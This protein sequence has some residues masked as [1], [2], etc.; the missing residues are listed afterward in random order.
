MSI[1]LSTFPG[2]IKLD[3]SDNRAQLPIIQ[4]PTPEKLVYPLTG[5]NSALLPVIRSADKVQ[6][7]D[8][9]AQADTFE[10]GIIRAGAT[11]IA[12]VKDDAI[13]LSHCEAQAHSPIIEITGNAVE[14]LYKLGVQGLGGAAFSTSGKLLSGADHDIHT[15]IINAAECEPV[16]CCDQA[17][18]RERADAIIHGI[19]CL[20]SISGA[21][22]CIIAI[23]DTMPIELALLNKALEQALAQSDH[24][25]QT[26]HLHKISIATIPTIYPTGSEKQLIRVLTGI[27]L[28]PEQ[29]P[30]DQGILCFNIA[31]AFA[32]QQALIDSHPQLDRVVTVATSE[33]TP[34]V[35]VRV[36]FG[37]RLTDLL[38]FVDAKI[39]ND[40][41]VTHGGPLTGYEVRASDTIITA[42]T[43]CVLVYPDKQAHITRPCIRC[44]ECDRVCPAQ[45]LPQQLHWHSREGDYTGAEKFHLS[46]CIECGCCDYVCPSQIPLTHQFRQA[47]K[48]I[49]QQ[50][51][52]AAAAAH[53]EARFVA[54]AQRLKHKEA[55]RQKKLAERKAMLQRK[56]QQAD[57]S[58]VPK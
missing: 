17:L 35:N 42:A 19:D 1:S 41:V 33:H 2:G 20:I 22:K 29:L 24:T 15:L 18:I 58:R 27:S 43:N 26:P 28:K 46:A 54:R 16:I 49:A 32:V 6:A 30:R 7:G 8:V 57:S 31:T 37:T 21:R 50:R 10:Q 44:G 45:L 51:R 38:H 36:L 53:A 39:N 13:L 34:P 14:C 56:R 25:N 47:K 9:I 23:E 52:K 4:M 55:L 3:S 11:G 12:T 40:G 48:S 5:K